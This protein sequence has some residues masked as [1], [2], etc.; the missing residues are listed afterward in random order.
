MPFPPQV[1]QWRSLFARHGS[2]LPTDLLL[3]W[4]WKES[5][6]NPCAT[7]IP[8]VE[9]GLFQ[10]YHPT[11]DRYGATFAQL[12]AACVGQ[13]QTRALSSDETLFHVKSG[14]AFVRD[15][16]NAARAHF[17]AAGIRFSESGTD[18]WTG[19]KQEH[20]LPCVMGGLLPRITA[21]LGR[22]PDSWAEIHQVAMDM[23]PAEMDPGCAGFAS[24][25]SMKG[26][27]NRLED[28]LVNAE[29]IGRFGGGGLGSLLVKAGLAALIAVAAYKLWTAN[30]PAPSSPPTTTP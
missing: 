7:G 12:R 24:A 30:D 25:P 26:L 13:S 27:R 19:V 9:A 28:T 22:P 15:K 1:E 10:T 3:A 2:D 4:A 23:S 14:L 20:A 16:K 29:E 11:D 6:G 18:F 8:G 17:A 21:R 5:D